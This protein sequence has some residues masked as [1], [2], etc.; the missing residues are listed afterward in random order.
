MQIAVLLA[1]GLGSLL[2]VFSG[3]MIDGNTLSKGW[4]WMYWISPMH[5]MLEIMIMAQFDSQTKFVVDTLTKSPVAINQ[6]VV[7]FFNGAFS[8]SNAGRDLGLLWVVVLVVQLLVLRCMAK[9]NH[10]TR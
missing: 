2:F 6:F 3:F 9:V 10:M 7:K 5:Y 4:Q 8:F 1:G